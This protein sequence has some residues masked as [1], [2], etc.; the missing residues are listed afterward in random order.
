M[1]ERI[2]AALMFWRSIHKEAVVILKN[3]YRKRGIF[4]MYKQ[5]VIQFYNTW[6]LD[7]IIKYQNV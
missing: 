4:F 6:F 5:Y 7:H 2:I 3:D 1:S